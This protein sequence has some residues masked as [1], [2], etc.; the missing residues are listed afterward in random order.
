MTLAAAGILPAAACGALLLVAV[1]WF[2]GRL[3]VVL[4][5]ANLLWKSQSDEVKSARAFVVGIGVVIATLVAAGILASLDS[6]RKI[7]T[8][9]N[10]ERIH[11]GMTESEVEAVLGKG[12]VFLP[13]RWL[14]GYEFP[15]IVVWE[16]RPSGIIPI[17]LER[18]S[19]EFKGGRVIAKSE[20]G[21]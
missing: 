16:Y 15:K 5:V 21:L 3:L 4:G 9:T 6:D 19:V 20:H 8:K 14:N 2:L 12:R 11:D 7:P 18:I 10:Y 1:S 17:P 13:G